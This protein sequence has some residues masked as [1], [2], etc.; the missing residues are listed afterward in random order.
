[1]ALVFLGS[2]WVDGLFPGCN[3]WLV[4]IGG[5][6]GLATALLG[7]SNLTRT[8]GDKSKPPT[9]LQISMDVA[10]IIS[11]IVFAIALI[12]VTSGLIDQL[13]FGTSFIEFLRGMR[14]I[15]QM[16]EQAVHDVLSGYAPVPTEAYYALAALLLTVA[17]GWVASKF[18]NINRFSLH[19]LYRNRL[20]RAFLG[21]SN[22]GSREDPES[23][24][25]VRRERQSPH[26]AA[27]AAPTRAAREGWRPFHVVNMALN[28]VSSKKLAWQ[29]R[30]AEPFT[31]SPLHSGSACKAYRSSSA[32][33]APGPGHFAR[34]GD[35]D[36][37]RGREPEHGLPL[38]AVD[39]PS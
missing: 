32:V 39:R 6:S 36:L 14:S 31:V 34:H 26:V 4:P 5:I 16:R 8:T 12:I 21:G 35:G 18:V 30:K 13:L 11:A 38:V 28:I 24:H 15:R 3:R 37:R 25:R 33:R 22:P 17:I 23:I 1:M 9:R 19:A 7:K 20:V 10:L 2:G 29:E 27:L